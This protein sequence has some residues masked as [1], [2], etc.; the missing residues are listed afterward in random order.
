MNI[1]TIDVGYKSL[2]YSIWING[3]LNKFDIVDILRNHSYKQSII[4]KNLDKFLYSLG[5]N[6]KN[7]VIES[8]FRSNIKAIRLESQIE[9]WFRVK[10]PETIVIHFPAKKKYIECDLNIYNSKYKRKKW[11]IEYV[12]KILNKE[13]TQIFLNLDK[14]DDVA[15]AIIIGLVYNKL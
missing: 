2:A 14:K 3:E 4:T 12:K 13:Q 6:F 8:Q 5:G 7:V 1:L 11:A 9:M 15:D 10:Y